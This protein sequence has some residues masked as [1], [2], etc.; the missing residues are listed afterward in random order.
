MDQIELAPARWHNGRRVIPI[1]GLQPFYS[2]EVDPDGGGAY[3]DASIALIITLLMR[4]KYQPF[5]SC[6][7]LPEDHKE[8]PPL[9][10]AYLGV[11][12][13][14]YR[15]VSALAYAGFADLQDRAGG[16]ARP[17]YMWS[18]NPK[19]YCDYKGNPPTV[20]ALLRCWRFLESELLLML[21]PKARR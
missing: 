12:P 14:D 20:E 8:P 18:T 19:Q 3:V 17:F 21:P 7:G 9:H 6:S 2:E 16:I 11:I 13:I 10:H 15:L 1:P 5:V 4:L